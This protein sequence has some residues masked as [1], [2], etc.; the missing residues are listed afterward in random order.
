MG[1]FSAG[2]AAVAMVVWVEVASAVP[3]D[4]R[5]RGE[6]AAPRSSG[7]VVPIG[8]VWVNGQRMAVDRDHDSS[9]MLAEARESP[10]E[11]AAVFD[12]AGDA[13]GSDDPEIPRPT[14]RSRRLLSAYAEDS[15]DSAYIYE[16]SGRVEEVEKSTLE[17]LES[18]GWAPVTSLDG[19]RLFARGPGRDRG[20][21]LVVRFGRGP[22]GTVVMHALRLTK[23]GA[24]RLAAPD[25][26]N[27]R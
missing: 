18:V 7:K 25:A 14:G 13:P 17:R 6:A 15:R 11:A 27:E 9:W 8:H 23:A 2:V 20:A 5:D 4:A 26:A 22:G 24:T 19:A 1:V 21:D 16:T 3:R 10:T 12:G